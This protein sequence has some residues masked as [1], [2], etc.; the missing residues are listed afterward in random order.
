MSQFSISDDLVQSSIFPNKT[1]IITINPRFLKVLENA[2]KLASLSTPVLITGESGVGKEMLARFI[3][4]M[5]GRSSEPFIGVNCASVPRDLMESEFFGYEAGSFTGANNSREGFFES[6]DGGTLFLDEVGEMPLSLQVKL[7]RAIQ[8]GEIRRLGACK[9]ISVDTRIV[10]ATNIDLEVAV[11]KK[12]F[13]EDLFYRLGVFLIHIPPLR[14][15]KED[16]SILANHFIERFSL[17]QKRDKPVLDKDALQRLLNY[18]WP[19]NVRELENVIER[20]LVF[21]ESEIKV[22]HLHF[23]GVSPDDSDFLCIKTLAEI[24][25]IAQQNAESSAILQALNLSQGNRVKAAKILDVSYKT[26]LN[27]IKQYELSL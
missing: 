1:E 7:L 9:T 25:Q 20:A 4:E 22:E 21:C 23:N 17:E 14:E 19:G 5:G 3:H 10:S 6:A 13:R 12:L 27:K 16:I 11:E 2:K 15:R 8:E 26:L 24:S 18:N